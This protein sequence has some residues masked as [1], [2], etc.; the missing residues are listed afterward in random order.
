MTLSE[1]LHKVAQEQA[2]QGEA[3]PPDLARKK[4]EFDANLELDVKEHKLQDAIDQE[5][6]QVK[7]KLEQEAAA[8]QARIAAEQAAKAAQPIQQIGAQP[9]P[10]A[11]T[12]MSAIPIPKQAG[13]AEAA[14]GPDS[15]ARAV[16]VA[17]PVLDFIELVRSK[18]PRNAT[19]PVTK[20]EVTEALI[21]KNEPKVEVKKSFMFGDNAVGRELDSQAEK[22]KD[23][24]LNTGKKTI[25][26][27]G[28]E[29]RNDVLSDRILEVIQKQAAQERT[30][31]GEH[32]GGVFLPGFH[33]QR[34]GE[35]SAELKARGIEPGFF[36]KYP[37]L[38]RVLATLAA[39]G[40]GAGLGALAGGAMGAAGGAVAGG[41]SGQLGDKALTGGLSG[42]MLGGLAG[43]V[44]GTTLGGILATVL[45]RRSSEKQLQETSSLP[46]KQEEV[47]KAME[48]ETDDNTSKIGNT[49]GGYIVPGKGAYTAG[50]AR[51]LQE[52]AEGKG[53]G[54]RKITP[55]TWGQLS[56]AVPYVGPVLRGA[57]GAGQEYTS[58]GELEE[59]LNKK[60]NKQEPK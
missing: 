49:L 10:V 50:Y 1:A 11:Q 56:A 37:T 12:Q 5:R 42:S 21:K 48:E 38:S 59:A 27:S 36:T 58:R 29:L 43:G 3:L 30:D 26:K 25:K 31:L 34:Q 55:G 7:Q 16:K 20:A 35:I 23:V 2:A 45:S 41:P 8:E 6:E 44:A 14:M 4:K 19:A 57:V 22:V 51:T 47:R 13:A 60:K 54:S 24:I 28:A 40:A 53:E 15:G 52:L 17:R 46:I 33:S 9:P 39:G 32:L 18:T